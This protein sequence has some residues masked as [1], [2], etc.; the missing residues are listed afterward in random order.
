[1]SKS[2][3]YEAEGP[4]YFIGETVQVTE[5]FRKREFVLTL[6]GDSKYPQLVPM[7]LTGDN[8]ARLDEFR[9]GEHVKVAFNLRGREWTKNGATKFFGEN[10][11]FKV[12]LVGGKVTRPTQGPPVPSGSAGNNDDDLPF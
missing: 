9:E 2:T 10:A 11:A 7:T 5:K 4:I 6:D 12:D 8:C 1:M 3:V